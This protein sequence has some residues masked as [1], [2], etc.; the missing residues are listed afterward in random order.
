MYSAFGRV[1]DSPAIANTNAT[2]PLQV[3]M[4]FETDAGV[5]SSV[6]LMLQPHSQQA[7]VLTALNPAVV[8]TRGSIKFTAPTADIAVTGL[9]FTQSGQFT[10]LETYQ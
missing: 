4:L 5:Q 9:E 8:G 2:Q 3:T 7:V 1:S 6:P 10:S